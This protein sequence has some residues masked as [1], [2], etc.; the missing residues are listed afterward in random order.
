V[1]EQDETFLYV[2]LSAAFQNRSRTGEYVLIRAEGDPNKL[3]GAVGNEAAAV[4]P[5]L[6]VVLRRVNDSLAYQMAPFRVV[7]SLAGVLGLLALLLASVGLYGVMSFIVTQ[8]T[9]EIGIRA[10]LGAQGSDVVS[11]FLRQGIKL[12]VLGIMIGLAGGAVISRLLAAV[13]VD[14]NPLDPLAFVGVAV[15]LTAIALLACYIPARRAT[16]VDPMIA[17]RCE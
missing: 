14:L 5:D 17:L 6:R 7:A 3:T 4:D 9:R 13:L 16:K 2:P 10:A 1:W 12:I 11:R 15:I 8:R